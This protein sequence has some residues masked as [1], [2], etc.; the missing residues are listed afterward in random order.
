MSIER[1]V[2]R[3]VLVAKAVLRDSELS[4]G[5]IVRQKTN[6]QRQAENLRLEVLSEALDLFQWYGPWGS[7]RHG[8]KMELIRLAREKA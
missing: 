7:T 1:L 3:G 5:G 4:P 2:E 6:R 8:I